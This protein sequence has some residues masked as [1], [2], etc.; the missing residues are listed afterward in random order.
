MGQ[1]KKLNEDIEPFDY[2]EVLLRR[3]LPRLRSCSRRTRRKWVD[4]STRR[5]TTKSSFSRA[6]LCG[7]AEMSGLLYL[8][9][10]LLNRIIRTVVRY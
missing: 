5:K 6:E 2:A 9:W 4:R 8:F 1:I 10:K 7:P 3:R